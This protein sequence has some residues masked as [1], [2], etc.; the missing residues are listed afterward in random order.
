MNKI[1]ILEDILQIRFNVPYGN[2]RYAEDGEKGD[3]FSK[4]SGINWIIKAE[5][6]RKAALV[7]WYDARRKERYGIIAK[8]IKDK[9]K[10][11]GRGYL[12]FDLG[13]FATIHATHPQLQ[14]DL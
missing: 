12:I 13:D 5:L 10:L 7:K 4:V 11:I 6:K 8:D 9:E 1:R 2:R 14:H 3:H